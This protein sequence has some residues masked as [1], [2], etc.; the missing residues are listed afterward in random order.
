[1]KTIAAILGLS[2]VTMS[3]MMAAPAF[4]DTMQNAY[5]NT[6]VVTDAHGTVVRY[7][8]NADGSFE[9]ITPDNQTVPGTYTV[10]NGQI[11]L[12]PAGG[13]AACTQYVGDKNVGDTWTQTATDGGQITVSVQAGR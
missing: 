11:C 6:I 5:A 10:A 8:F 13:Q 9:L 3:A 4:A 2:A 12:T 7:H 1:M